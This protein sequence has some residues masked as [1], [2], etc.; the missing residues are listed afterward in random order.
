[1]PCHTPGSSRPGSGVFSNAGSAQ[2][3]TIGTVSLAFEKQKAELNQEDG[4]LW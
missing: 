4:P 2:R 1:M 3:S